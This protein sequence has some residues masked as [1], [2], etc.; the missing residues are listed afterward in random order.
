MGFHED[1]RIRRK[2]AQHNTE[3]ENKKSINT[4]TLTLKKGVLYSEVMDLLDSDKLRSLVSIV[5][6]TK[7]DQ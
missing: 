1:D 4:V 2:N 3:P 6:H 7:E 5:L